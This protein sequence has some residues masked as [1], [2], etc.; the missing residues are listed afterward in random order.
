MKNR[1]M[2]KTL[3]EHKA[4]LASLKLQAEARKNAAFKIE[5]ISNANK[6]YIDTMFSAM[7][8]EDDLTD[9]VQKA[10]LAY[11]NALKKHGFSEKDFEYAPSCPICFDSG[12]VD[13]RPC[14]CIWAKYIRNLEAECELA[15]KAPFSFESCRLDKIEDAWQRK[16]LESIYESMKKYVDKFP[17]S[18]C[19]SFVFS[20]GVGTGKSCLASAIA[21]GIVKKGYAAKIMSAYEFNSLM[22]TIH[23]SPIAERNALLSDVLSADMLLID[24]LG[25]EPMLKNV[26][27]EYLLLVLEERQLK[28]LASFITTNLSGEN[29]LN[30]YGE[31]IYSRLSHK[32]RSLIIAFQG[33][34]LRLS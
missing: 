4:E 24:D 3:N 32:Q 14:K 21:N 9:D 12:K 18:R 17:S 1:V 2:Q 28:G 30:R 19:T 33:R 22:L 15:I 23:T 10:S 16:S 25:T 20:G 6:H 5:E 7:T 8:S 13:G 27:V 11:Q 29:I 31:R 26:T 34:D